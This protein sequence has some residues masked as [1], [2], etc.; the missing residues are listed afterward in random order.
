MR[1]KTGR[2]IFTAL[3]LLSLS[4]V[5]LSSAREQK[6]VNFSNAKNHW[7]FWGGYGV[8]HPGFG[9]TETRIEDVDL[10][11]QYGHF[12]T[13]EKGK[14]WYKGR[15]ELL[16]EIPL[17]IVYHPERAIMTGIN[18]LACWN[19]TASEEI[20]PY[21]FAGGG[22][23]YTNLNIP[24]LGKELNGN[25]QSGIGVHYFIEKDFSIDF[26]YRLHHISNANTADPNEPLNSS[27]FLVGM[28]FLM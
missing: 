20:V 15:H 21:I 17:Y 24:G 12:L 1:N 14:S 22:P 5:P 13:E 11:L 9:D 4:Y 7:T 3:M 6:A 8:T 23:L 10:I 26:N 25:Y 19:F 27:K 2:R 28:T 18:F 16:I